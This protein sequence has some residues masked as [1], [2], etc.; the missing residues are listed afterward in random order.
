MKKL[1]LSCFAATL[2]F[3][4]KKDE[5][6]NS[7]SGLGNNQFKIGA[8]TYTGSVVAAM[9][10]IG[11]IEGSGSTAHAVSIAFIDSEFPTTGGTFKVVASADFDAADEVELSASDGLKAYTSTTGGTVVVTV[12]NGKITAK[13]TDIT[14]KHINNVNDVTKISA[15]IVQ[16]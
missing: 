5:D 11:L 6:K 2:L 14:V 9:G 7:P 12:N 8:T 4:C 10:T 3:S 1:L 15:N 13:F 16:P